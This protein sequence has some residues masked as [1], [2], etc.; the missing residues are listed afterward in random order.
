MPAVGQELTEAWRVGGFA[1]PESVSYDPASQTLFVSN[2]NSPDVGANGEGY[3]WQM[4]LEGDV[5]SERFVEGL[6]A[7]EGTVI[8]DGTLCLEYGWTLLAKSGRG[9]ECSQ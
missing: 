7:P 6:N 5:I 3:I 4:S 2:I 9:R 8:V 1:T